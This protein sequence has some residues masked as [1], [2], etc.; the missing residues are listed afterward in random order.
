[1]NYL[2]DIDGTLLNGSEPMKGAKE[3]VE[4]LNKNGDKYLL[5][6]NSIK[7]IEV[8]QKRLLQA[9][10]NVSAQRIL[11]PI[12]AINKYLL[13]SN[14]KKVK[15]VGTDLEINQV[16]ASN[17]K[18]GYEVVVLLDFEKSNFGYDVIQGIVDDAENGIKVVTASLS[19]Y[20]LKNGK[21]AVDTGSFVKVVEGITGVKI[22]NY[23]K[24]SM[25]YFG[26]AGKILDAEKESIYVIGDDWSTDILGAN[27][28]GA[29]SVLVKTGKYKENDEVK[30][31]PFKTL[32]SLSE[33]I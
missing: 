27:E 11:N 28:Y 1:M 31:N 8:Q 3:F 7:S 6:T 29:K 24:P 4:K 14:I 9:G 20:Y 2:I 5:M 18:E 21:K 33:E 26:I 13:D 16:K 12:V 17:V 22:D 23:G 15:V 19:P 32:E 10:I 30:C 25:A